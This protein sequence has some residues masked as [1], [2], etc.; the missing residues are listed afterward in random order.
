MSHTAV[1]FMY[2]GVDCNVLLHPFYVYSFVP[3]T[4]I[5]YLFPFFPVVLPRDVSILFI[6]PEKKKKKRR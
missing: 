3:N 1:E 2:L 6:L 4:G 5:L